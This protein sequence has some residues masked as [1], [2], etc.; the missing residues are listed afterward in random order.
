MKKYFPNTDLDHE[1]VM[2]LAKMILAEEA[3]Q[4]YSKET[5]EYEWISVE[6]RLPIH[7]G[8]VLVHDC[9]KSKTTFA[10]YHRDSWTIGFD[11]TVTHWMPMPE[12]P[13]EIENKHATQK[14]SEE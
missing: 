7:M 14:A 1:K 2:K 3:T 5:L 10:A 11:F 13:N 4:N 12:A 9:L 8:T 6:D